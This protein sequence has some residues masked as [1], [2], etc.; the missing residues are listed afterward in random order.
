MCSIRAILSQSHTKQVFVVRRILKMPMRL[1]MTLSPPPL[2]SRCSERR[3]VALPPPP[4]PSVDDRPVLLRV[5]GP[6]YEKWTSQ[7]T[8]T[9]INDRPIHSTTAHPAKAVQW[10]ETLV[11]GQQGI[12]KVYDPYVGPRSPYA[13]AVTSPQPPPRRQFQ[14]PTVNSFDKG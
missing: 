2:Q 13:N 8:E 7:R 9:L 1:L 14:L 5:N 4:V 10:K 12:K 11:D 6:G 3:V